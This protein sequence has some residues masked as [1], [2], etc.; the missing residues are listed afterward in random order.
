MS[1][2]EYDDDEFNELGFTM[3]G[4]TY[5]EEDVLRALSGQAEE[6]M[7]QYL[8]EWLRSI[9]V[10]L[11]STKTSVNITKGWA[12]YDLLRDDTN[13]GGYD[14]DGYNSDG[15]NS[16]GHNLDGYNPNQV[17]REHQADCEHYTF[18]GISTGSNESNES[19]EPKVIG[20]PVV[21]FRNWNDARKRYGN[22]P[23]NARVFKVTVPEDEY[24]V[25]ITHNRR[26][27]YEGKSPIFVI[28]FGVRG[29]SYAV[30]D[31]PYEETGVSDHDK[32]E[33]MASNPNIEEKEIFRAVGLESLVGIVCCGYLA[34]HGYPDTQMCRIV[35]N[36][37]VAVQGTRFAQDVIRR[38]FLEGNMDVLWEFADEETKRHVMTV[39]ALNKFVSDD[40]NLF[41]E[42]GETEYVRAVVSFLHNY[43][44]YGAD[45]DKL[46]DEIEQ[47]TDYYNTA[48]E[49]V[50]YLGYRYGEFCQ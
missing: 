13:F 48:S 42:Y 25:S 46:F 32:I 4:S 37:V 18:I 33:I 7:K 38:Y 34:N 30:L 12:L 9:Y 45:L 10:K 5:R 3:D 26:L 27:G 47:D 8:L 11:Y 19:N 23:L 15:Y 36:Q 1:C 28:P 6:Q 35:M 43:L 16:D 14:S 44:K 20:V 40:V 24:I 2:N 29:P 49:M 17:R 39:Y 50:D 21:V 22:I 41:V 31:A